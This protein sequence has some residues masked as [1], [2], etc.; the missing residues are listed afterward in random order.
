VEPYLGEIRMFGGSFAPAGWFFC[1]GQR[2]PISDH[3]ELFTLLGARYGGD[4]QETF[5]LPDLRGRWALGVGQSDPLAS[6]GGAEQVVLS[7]AQMPVHQHGFLGSAAAATSTS[8]ANAVWGATT[9]PGYVPGSGADVSAQP[10]AV[11][12]LTP[13]GDGQAHD[14]LPPYLPVRFIIASYGTYP[15]AS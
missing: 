13:V 5:A 6:T 4:G 9:D 11:D 3:E 8:P 1:D 10:M 12:A 14:N 15:M 2:L 7:T